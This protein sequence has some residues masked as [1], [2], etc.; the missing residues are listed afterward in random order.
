MSE[1]NKFIFALIRRNKREIIR[2]LTVAMVGSLI[3]S[4]VP[5][6]YGKLFDLA[7]I[8]NS[9]LN[10][11]LSLIGLWFFVNIS[12]NFISNKT[13][14]MGEKLG[15]KIYSDTSADSYSHFIK[16]PIPFHKKERRGEVLDKIT[17]SANRLH[18]LVDVFSS[19]LPYFLMLIIAVVVMF[20]LQ[21]QLAIVVILSFFIYTIAT[22]AKTKKLMKIRLHEDR[23]YSKQYGKIYDKLQNVFLV[24]NFAMEEQE[25][26][27]IGKRMSRLKNVSAYATKKDAELST[28]QDII[29]TIGFVSVLSLAILF[30]RSGDL[31]SGQFI[32]FFGY[33][34][35]AF[36]PFRHITAIYRNFRLVTVSIR[37]LVNLKRMVP[38]EMK[39]GEK[40]IPDFRGEIDFENISF[41]YP[42]GKEVLKNMSLKIKAG[43]TVALVGKSGVGK[44]T[45]SELILGYY[46][47]E[48][49][50]IKFDGIEISKLKLKWLRDQIAIVPQDLNL[51]NETLVN[52]LKYAKPDATKEQILSATKAAH[53]HEFIEKFPKKYSSVVGEEG[54]KLS[55][56]QRQRIAIAMA[57]LKNPK[58]LILDEPTSALDAESERKVQEGINR[59]IHGRTTI[60]I[61]H[62]FSTVRK[63]NRI[64]VLDKG[65]IAEMG[66]HNE[67]MRKK[68]IYH[69]L[70]S[71]QRGTDLID[72]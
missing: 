27:D 23:F 7:I 71:L 10:F 16:L 32:T 5:F 31:T 1:V 44:T 65:K 36:A 47:P 64:I 50:K 12:S 25:K 39:H 43:E 40:I 30:L 18:S 3:A 13:V 46:R 2:I 41:K 8:P 59:L 24:K 34:N 48:N 51:F 6:I 15:V 14:E 20:F 66:N 29:Y 4:G 49:G 70:Y 68:G 54:I 52:N 53:A 57:F 42:K 56:G 63:A 62:R 26:E 21:W 22:I 17:R 72:K 37:R 11:I 19:T 35:M 58:I 61:A 45:L 28:I 9:S 33:T 55:M 69:N 60:I 67:L 38:E